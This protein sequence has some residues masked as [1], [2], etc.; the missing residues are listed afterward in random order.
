[1][2]NSKDPRS[3]FRVRIARLHHLRRELRTHLPVRWRYFL[4]GGTALLAVLFVLRTWVL[5]LILSTLSF[6][7]TPFLPSISADAPLASQSTIIYDRTG[8]ELYTIHGSENRFEIPLSKMPL[9]I[10]KATIS[11]E[12]ENFYTHPGFDVNGLMAAAASEFGIGRP[13]GG[14][15]ITQQFVKNTYLSSERSYTRKITELLMAVKLESHFTKDQILEMYLNRIPYGNNAYGIQAAALTYFGKNAEDLSL[16]ES[17]VLAG[18]PQAPSKYSPYG[19]GKDLLMGTCASTDAPTLFA[20]DT[21]EL[22]ITP[23]TKEWLQIFADG[24]LAKQWTA[25]AGTTETIPFKNTLKI[26]R[27]KG[28]L[29][30]AIQGSPLVAQSATGTLTLT[31]DALATEL[32]DPTALSR[33]SAICKDANDKNYTPGRA[34]YVLG[35][36]LHLGYITQADYDTAWHDKNNL[37]FQKYHESIKAPHFVFY[38]RDLLEQRYGKD[39]VEQGGLRVLTTLDPQLQAEGEHQIE[40][41]FPHDTD[42]AGNPTNWRTNSFNANNASLL[43]TDTQTG[44]ILAMVGSRDYFEKQNT[45]G[46]G[47]DGAVNLTMRPRQPGSSFKP[48]VYAAG[49][50]AGYQPGSVL[51]DVDTQFGAEKYHPKNFEGSFYGPMTIR[52]ALDGS[53]NI[54]AIKMAILVGEKAI[55]DLV[56]AFGMT[57]IATDGRYGPTI[58]I[59]AGEVT[60][61]ELAQGYM[62]FGNNG[63]QVTPQGILRVTDSAGRIIDDFDPTKSLHP[64]IMEPDLAYLITDILTDSSARPSGWNT[65]MTLPDRLVAAKTGTSDKRID[66]NNILP[67]DAWMASYTPQITAL[68]WMGN[69]DGSPM[70]MSA[71]G[72]RTIG[73]IWSAFMK[74]AHEGKPVLSFAQPANIVTRSISRYSGLL[75]SDSTPASDIVQEKFADYLVPLQ[76]DHSYITLD[77]DKISGKR[78]TADTPE[79]ARVTRTFI[80]L[81]S[82]RP[83]DPQWENPVRAWIAGHQAAGS[84]DTTD[85]TDGLTSS[86]AIAPTDYDTVHT[87][88]TAR[89]APSI[90]IT[91]PLTGATVSPG[92]ITLSLDAIAPYGLQKVEYYRENE[93]VSTLTQAPWTGKVLIPLKSSGTQIHITAKAYDAYGYS[94]TSTITLTVGALAP[95]ATVT[96]SIAFTAPT[97]G[98]TVTRGTTLSVALDVP[99]TGAGVATISLMWNGRLITTLTQAPY[100][101]TIPIGPITRLGKHTLT[102]TIRDGLGNEKTIDTTFVVADAPV[103]APTADTPTD[104]TTTPTTPITT[105]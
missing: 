50:R 80:N 32:A 63:K 2:N 4:I 19:N 18:L 59:G 22:S 56:R 11:A 25:V 15:T 77:I 93:L 61:M 73:P 66:A 28:T 1:M 31:R 102:A 75:A 91:A 13:R 60:M 54:P 20:T 10:Q 35:R 65:Y 47:N 104:A 16:A 96:P 26:I 81:H 94:A 14:S 12:D 3:T 88:T 70:N 5:F 34:D 30:L 62:V 41:S 85:T 97:A 45:D 89:R 36:M 101:T 78:A 68:V 105:P 37:S 6:L 67:E 58:G 52:K 99:D 53:R 17:A 8:G 82:E 69:N 95:G 71:S 57:D 43:A 40:N 83:T 21:L 27:G 7:A 90:A 39:L 98:T 38:I 23:D 9:A 46:K 64:Q 42:A 87:P 103:P 44:E 51:W 48:F 79:G 76:L 24:K 92:Q 29:H 55:V 74:K 33:T 100:T 84:G 86:F 72:F 49:F